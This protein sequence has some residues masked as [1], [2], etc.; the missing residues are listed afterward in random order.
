VDTI[1]TGGRGEFLGITDQFGVA[2][3]DAAEGRKGL[4]RSLISNKD[5]AANSAIGNTALF[6]AYEQETLRR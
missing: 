6:A 2:I 4:C 5:N 3:A 1:D